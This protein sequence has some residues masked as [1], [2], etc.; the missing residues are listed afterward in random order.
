MTRRRSRGY[1][2]WQSATAASWP[3]GADGNLTVTGLTYINA[4]DIKNY[5]NLTITSTG[6]LVVRGITNLG[7]DVNDGTDPTIIGVAGNLTIASGGQII[8]MDNGLG[9]FDYNAS[10]FNYTKPTPAGAA[11]P[12]ISYDA[13]LSFGG[14]GGASQGGN[15]IGG[16]DSQRTGMAG[17]GAG[18][19]NGSDST[20][21]IGWG[22]SGDGAIDGNGNSIA[23]GLNPYDFGGFSLSG[24]PGVGGENAGGESTGGGGSG[25]VR[26][27]NG[28]CLYIQVAGTITVAG[29]CFLLAGTGGG[30]GGPGGIGSSP[31]DDSYGGGGAGGGAGGGGGTLIIR[32]K[33]GTVSAANATVIGGPG[34]PAGSGGT[35][36]GGGPTNLDGEAGTAGEDGQNGVVDIATY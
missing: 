21:D 31:D 11:I 22:R 2:I 26:G 1:H 3:T 9:Q 34:G 27:L 18:Y 29:V 20:I 5:N 12:L 30:E 24:S 7:F 19:G 13:A 6:R 17:G 8:C 35:G 33:L 28:G 23:S 10:S 36:T 14:E 15:Y 32:Y 4:G 25:G 16:V